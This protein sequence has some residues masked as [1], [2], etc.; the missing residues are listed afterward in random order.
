MNDDMKISVVI[1]TYNR[2]NLLPRALESVLMQSYQDFE[3]FIYDNCSS[4]NT[5]DVVKEY[6]DLDSRIH[7]ICRDENIGILNNMKQ[8]IEAVTSPYY[9]LLNDDDFL[10]ADQFEKAMNAFQSSDEIGFV[11]SRVIH[12]DTRGEKKYFSLMNQ[13]WKAG[14]YH[15]SKKVS[16][17]MSKDHFSFTCVIFKKKVG[18]LVGFVDQSVNDKTYFTIASAATSFSVLDS[19]GGVNILHDT[20]FTGQGLLSKVPTDLI[21]EGGVESITK[22]ET[23][24]ISN[25]FKFHLISL[26]LEQYLLSLLWKKRNFLLNNEKMKS[27][28][29]DLHL[30]S[31]CS[32]T[33]I[34]IKLYDIFPG[35]THSILKTLC[36]L[37][38]KLNHTI[39]IRNKSWELLPASVEKAINIKTLNL[40]PIIKL[41]K[42]TD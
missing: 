22:I 16:L 9:C 3:I 33:S 42:K 2:A 28:L 8:G 12:I 37:A 39:K 1:C 11:S 34:I 19:Y 27:S 14:I 5:K 30:F 35:F 23:L 10:L 32:L 4:D 6:M 38:I 13:G 40:E 31:R 24:N 29:S 15:P 7:Y 18:A 21:C 36:N 17:K 20:S 25:E 41:L 26:V